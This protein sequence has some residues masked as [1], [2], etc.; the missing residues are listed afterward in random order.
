MLDPA[1]LYHRVSEQIHELIRGG[2]LRPGDRVP[3]VRRLSHQQGIS[4]STVLQAYQR[5]EDIGVIESRPQSG[6]YVRAS[7]LQMPEPEP[8]PSLPPVRALSVEVNTLVEAVLAAAV[9]PKMISFGSACPSGELFPLEKVRR[10]L[11]SRA[12]R[13]RAT[14]GRY[15]LPPGSAL[16]RRAVA[17]RA[18][19]WGCRLDYRN[20]VTTNGCMEAINLALRA[21]TRAGDMVAIESPAYYGFLQ[22]LESLGLRALEISTHPRHGLSLEALEL[23]LAEHDIKAV[24][25]MPSVSNPLGATMPDAAKKRLVELLAARRVPLIEDNI[26]GDLAYA[27]PSPRAAKSFDRTGNVI[28]ASSFSKTLAPGLKVGWIEPGRWG[29]RIRTMK[30]V[31]SGGQTELTEMAV[32]ELIGSSGYERL[33]RQLRRR[34]ETHVDAARSAIAAY[35]PRG[36][37]VTRPSGGFVLWVEMPA[38]CDSVELFRRALEHGI[39]IAPGPMFSATH[40]HRNCMRLSIG[41]IWSERI[42]RALAELGRLAHALA[43]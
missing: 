37:K 30:F 25:A 43:S 31:A 2:T 18:L 39:S 19:E 15:G 27:G 12:R 10:A 7:S 17:R 40:R 3:S 29:E 20:I 8:Q 4:I 9:D 24:L 14:L 16:L 34:F 21:L 42:E 5:L 26:Y 13:D 35:F 33:Q 36:T 41:E 32:A 22:I 38:G 28:L 23:A 6:Y 1:P 11:A